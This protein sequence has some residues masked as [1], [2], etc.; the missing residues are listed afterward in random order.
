MKH[1]QEALFRPRSYA[2][3]SKVLPGT[4]LSAADGQGWLEGCAQG[5]RLAPRGA[6]RSFGDAAF[7]VPEGLT[8]Q[9]PRGGPLDLLPEEGLLWVDAG[10]GVGSVH[11]R[12][13][14]TPF[15]FPVYGGT[16]WATVG[17][18]A[19]GDI[20]GK[21]HRVEGSFGRHVQAL[22]LI[23]ASGETLRCSRSRHADLFH[24]T[25]GGMGLTGLI[26]RVGLGV[27][28]HVSLALSVRRRQVEGLGD[29]WSTL[30]RD[31]APDYA[32]ATFFDLA[33]P[34]AR[35][36]VFEAE[37]VSSPAPPPRLSRRIDLPRLPLITAEAVRGVGRMVLAATR[38]PLETLVHRRDFN[39]SGLHEHLYGWNQL[40]GLKG[41]IEYQFAASQAVFPSLVETFVSLARA[42]RA[43]M[44]AAVIK[45]M[46][47]LESGGL[48]SFPMAGATINF[49]TPWS[50][51]ALSWLREGTEA[52]IAA[53]GRINLTKDCC[54][55]AGQMARMY[56]NLERWREVVRSYD[57]QGRVLT[58]LG[59]RL[60]LKPWSDGPG[61]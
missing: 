15:E 33:E 11:Q 38:A 3:W 28:P 26:T 18:G 59:R 4:S 19:A 39:Y 27:R 56:P 10:D 30:W 50:P 58:A 61:G 9:A 25:L 60:G 52:V 43:P 57:P 49:Q 44:L 47:A 8:C 6:G 31:P 53:G 21:N 42:H 34:G 41:M 54:L 51:G 7:G 36:L 22:D 48:L 13:E 12:L 16:Q 23:L 35:G 24:A 55:E 2:S 20:H 14:D 37:S 32:F 17:G 5:L 46:G 29:L 1:T 40:Y 45:P